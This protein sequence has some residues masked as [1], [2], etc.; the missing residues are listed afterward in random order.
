MASDQAEGMLQ[1]GLFDVKKTAETP[2]RVQLREPFSVGGGGGMGCEGT[3]AR[4][5]AL[6]GRSFVASWF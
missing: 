1:D 3:V 5:H 4:E 6:R 2:T